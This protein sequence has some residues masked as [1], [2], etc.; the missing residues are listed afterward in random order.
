MGYS[1]TSLVEYILANALTRGTSSGMPVEIINVGNKVRD[2]VSSDSIIQYIRW[3]D[4]E[5]DSALSTIYKV[6]LKRIVKGEFETL[7]NISIG[8]VTFYIEDS[9]R[10]SVGDMINVTDRIVNEKKIISAIP[11]ETTIGVSAAFINSFFGSDSIVQRIGYPDPIPL[12]SARF[13]AANLYDKHF[14]S[15][16]S[17]NISDYGKSLRIMAE[18]DLN[19]ILNGRTR[20]V[21]Q[22]WLGRR[23][24][25]PVLL[26]VNSIASSDKNREKP[27]A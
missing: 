2:T 17:P 25:N 19:S 23:F 12:I 5:L 3:A 14:A 6:P 15:Q 1:T 13:S 21:G 7:N 27:N 20:L 11:D 16:A 8:D 22:K 24:F 10:F 18:N 9:T 26:D 4:E